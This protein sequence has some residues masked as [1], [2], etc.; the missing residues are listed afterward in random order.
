MEGIAM[1]ATAD[2]E[3]PMFCRLTSS[4]PILQGHLQGHLHTNRAGIT[5]KYVAQWLRRILHQKLGQ[6][7]GRSMSE[8]AKHYMTHAADLI[9][10]G[11]IQLRVGVAMDRAPPR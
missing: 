11:S 10:Q 2:S 1:I 5:E 8:A 4:L 7:N 3:E 6:L 9:L